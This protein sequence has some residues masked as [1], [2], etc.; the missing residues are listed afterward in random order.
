M[1]PHLGEELWERTGHRQSVFSTPLPA[2]APEYVR[3][4]TFDLV[5]QV[6]SKIRARESVASDT[7]PE[8]MKAL[9]LANPRI[10]EILEGRTPRRVIVIQ[11]RLV[12]IVV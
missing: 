8:T 9:A 6:N 1:T 7:D 2:A 11:N 5:I 3:S 10:Q 12:N 4:E